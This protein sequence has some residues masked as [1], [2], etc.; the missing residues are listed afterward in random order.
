MVGGVGVKPHRRWAI[1]ALASRT[2]GPCDRPAEK[3]VRR[4]SRE[5][6]NLGVRAGWAA[7]YRAECPGLAV[8]ISFR[9]RVCRPPCTFTGCQSESQALR[10]VPGPQSPRPL[11]PSEK[12]AGS[13]T[14]GPPGFTETGRIA[15][16]RPGREAAAWL[17]RNGPETQRK[18][19]QAQGEV[20]SAWRPG[21]PCRGLDLWWGL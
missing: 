16:N 9:S 12:G 2:K 13:S 8:G 4:S 7:R 20:S 21:W 6:P 14:R 19:P 1:L 11:S 3:R 15:P 10:W 17:R 5:G 18:Q